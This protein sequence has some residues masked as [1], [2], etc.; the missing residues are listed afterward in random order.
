M[1]FYYF[2]NL[3]IFYENKFLK[4]LKDLL[5]YLGFGVGRS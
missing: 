3:I 5:R 2:L 4:F 1:N